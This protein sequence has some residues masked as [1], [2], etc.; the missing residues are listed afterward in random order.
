MQWI[1]LTQR[2]KGGGQLALQTIH[3]PP[4]HI[5]VDWL[6][7]G[8]NISRVR[9]FV[10]CGA[11][12]LGPTLISNLSLCAC[13]CAYYHRP[14]RGQVHQAPAHPRQSECRNSEYAS[15]RSCC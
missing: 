13:A 6:P 8:A 4:S 15:T 2:K 9:A 3:R 11:P 5:R 10:E 12:E 7:Q 1:T 14:D